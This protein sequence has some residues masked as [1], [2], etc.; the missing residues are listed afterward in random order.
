MIQSSVKRYLNTGQDLLRTWINQDLLHTWIKLRLYQALGDIKLEVVKII[1]IREHCQR[2]KKLMLHCKLKRIV[3]FLFLGKK[4]IYFWTTYL[5]GLNNIFPLFEGVLIYPLVIFFLGSPSPL[6]DSLI[7][8]PNDISMCKCD[9]M[10]PKFCKLLFFS[11][12]L[13]TRV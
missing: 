6:E 10:T 9:D 13:F 4:I 2:K 5:L 12:F 7:L 11:I 8:N 1:L 3:Y